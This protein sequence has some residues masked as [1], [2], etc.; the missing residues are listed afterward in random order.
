MGRVAME[1]VGTKSARAL[2]VAHENDPSDVSLIVVVV[3]GSVKQE[4]YHLWNSNPVP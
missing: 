1:P 3:V 2:V 4:G